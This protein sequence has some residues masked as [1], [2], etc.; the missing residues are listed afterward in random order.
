MHSGFI[1][2]HHTVFHLGSLACC[3]HQYFEHA[4]LILRDHLQQT[5]VS[6]DAVMWASEPALRFRAHHW[7]L[8]NLLHPALKS[9]K[10]QNHMLMPNFDNFEQNC[11][12]PTKLPQIPA[13]T[14][15]SWARTLFCSEV[16]MYLK[17]PSMFRYS[18]PNFE[19]CLFQG[20]CTRV[21]EA[22]IYYRVVKWQDFHVLKKYRRPSQRVPLLAFA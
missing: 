15:N 6:R 8:F 4:K 14:E 12:F 21:P 11:Q 20:Q 2:S 3:L 18:V 1:T 9:Q 22:T 17:C 13:G 16:K 10:L 7:K 5:F 19:G